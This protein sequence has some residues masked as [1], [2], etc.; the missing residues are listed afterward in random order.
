MSLPLLGGRTW[1]LAL[2]DLAPGAASADRYSFGREEWLLVL[3]GTP[4]LRRPQG[5]DALRP[6]DLACLPVGPDGAHG[7]A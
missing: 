7:Q 5:E 1:A 2:E 6:G 4:S 3:A